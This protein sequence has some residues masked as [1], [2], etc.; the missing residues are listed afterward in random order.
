MTDLSASL[1]LDQNFHFWIVPS[2]YL[3]LCDHVMILRCLKRKWVV[4]EE[5][6]VMDYLHM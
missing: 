5:V 2:I 4:V 6:F 3:D 1:I